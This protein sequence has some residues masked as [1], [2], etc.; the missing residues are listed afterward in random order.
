MEIIRS[1]S[2]MQQRAISARA[3]GQSISFVPTMGFL[4]QGHLSLLEE[5]RKRGDL[6][7]LSIFV[8]PT[9]FGQ[10]EDFEDYPRDLKQDSKLAQEMGVDIIFAPEAAEMYPTGYATYVD[11]EGITDNLCGTSRPGHFRGVCTVVAKL[12]NIVQPHS[13][14][15][16]NKDFQQLAVIR[17]MTI[18]MNIPVEIIGKVIFRESDGLAMSSRNVYLTPEQR[19]QALVLSQSLAKAREQVVSGETACATIIAKLQESISNQPDARIDYVQICHQL[20]LE[21]Q[22]Y[23][24][25]DSVLLLAVYLGSTRLIDNGFLVSNND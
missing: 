6:L 10:G 14:I 22:D 13:A 2:E 8:N 15:F 11:V 7:I 21:D 17:R 18:D 24:D 4:H 12:F 20:T 1:V 3:A 5:G 9:Q 16:G 23:V 25:T 19:E